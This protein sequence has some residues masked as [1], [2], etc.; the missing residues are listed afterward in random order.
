MKNPL[1]IVT[2]LYRFEYIENVYNSIL[3][4][5]DIVW[6]ICISNKRKDFEFSKIN[7]DK[8]IKF[9]SVDCEDNDTT[10][11][12][13]TILSQITDGYFCFLDDDTIFHE[14]MYIK[15]LECKEEN[16]KGMIVGEQLDK[17]GKLRL[18]ASPPKY[19][20][21]D[22]GNVIAHWECLKECKYPQTYT[23]GKDAKDFLF[24]ESVYKYYNNKC[25]IWNQPISHY[26][27]L[28]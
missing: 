16:F 24:W 14:N 25:G 1:H 22:V 4:N 10:L 18:I 6:H 21:I 2:I 9:Y 27:K 11:K 13:N 8:R 5:D 7:K 28:R 17:N 15:Y 26:N 23:P 19:M 20:R 12:R 3:M